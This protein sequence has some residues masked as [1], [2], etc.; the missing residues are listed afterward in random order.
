MVQFETCDGPVRLLTGSPC[1]SLLIQIT[2]S[3]SSRFLLGPRGGSGLILLLSTMQQ[4]QEE[5]HSVRSAGPTR[6]TATVG[7]RILSRLDDGTGCSSPE[8]LMALWTEEGIRN[9]RD[10][11]QVSPSL[12]PGLEPELEPDPGLDLGLR[13]EPGPEPEPRLEPELQ[14]GA[15]LQTYN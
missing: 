9:S 2:N 10:I 3:S 7:T 4:P 13:L 6:L 12:E 1:D 15:E 8:R 14:P 11:L 5:Q